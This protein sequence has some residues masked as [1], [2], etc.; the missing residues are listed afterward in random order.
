MR[1][2]KGRRAVGWVG[3]REIRIGIGD[4]G[5]FRADSG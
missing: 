5:S 3:F 4:L 1:E 2:R